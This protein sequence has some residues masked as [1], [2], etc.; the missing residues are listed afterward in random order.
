VLSS[1]G[2][3]ISSVSGRACG[4]SRPDGGPFLREKNGQASPIASAADYRWQGIPQRSL[5][6][7]YGKM[8]VLVSGPPYRVDPPGPCAG[9]EM[10]CKS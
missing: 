10:C 7:H 6:S 1:V 8:D 3:P 4:T 9:P 5:T 2:S